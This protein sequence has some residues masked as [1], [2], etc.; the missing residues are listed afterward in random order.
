VNWGLSFRATPKVWFGSVHPANCM[1]S[2]TSVPDTEPFPYSMDQ[3][4]PVSLN[5]ELEFCPRNLWSPC[6]RLKLDGPSRALFSSRNCH[7]RLPGIAP[8]RPNSYLVRV[9][10]EYL[11]RETTTDPHVR[12]TRIN[13]QTERLARRSKN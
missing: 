12:G 7:H 11:S 13:Q 2:V 4:L 10:L 3:G 6:T 8:H 9:D 1:R 5:D